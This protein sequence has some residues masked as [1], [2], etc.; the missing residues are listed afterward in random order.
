VDAWS[1][2]SWRASDVP[3]P[4][5]IASVRQ[6]LVRELAQHGG[7]TQQVARSL[8]CDLADIERWLQRFAL[9]PE[10]YSEH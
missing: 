10:A 7:D 8:K 9:E 1:R 5:R 3:T 4:A 2:A 6:T